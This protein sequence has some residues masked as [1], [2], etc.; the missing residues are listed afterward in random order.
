MS[1]G[2]LGEVYGITAVSMETE[3]VIGLSFLLGRVPKLGKWLEALVDIL[4]FPFF[5]SSVFCLFENPTLG[6][7]L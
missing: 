7:W 6:Q 2:I 3:K 5:P 4:L 1:H